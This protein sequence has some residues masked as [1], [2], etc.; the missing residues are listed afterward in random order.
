VSLADVLSQQEKWDDAASAAREALRLN[1]NNDMARSN[2]GVVLGGKK[3]MDGMIAEEREALRVNPNND[4]AHAA[5][6]AALEKKGDQGGALQ[7]YRAAYTLD[8]KNANY[9]KEYESAIQR[10][11][12]TE[13]PAKPT[14]SALLPRSNGD[15]L[16]NAKTLCIVQENGSPV[17]K[18]E[19]EKKLLKWGHLTLV[20]SVNESDL[21]LVIA[22][23]G[24]LNIVTGE[25]NQAAVSLKDR[26]SGAVLWSTTKGGGWSYRGFSNAWVGRAIADELTKFITSSTKG[27][28]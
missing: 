10:Q 14:V 7:E 28:K 16:A 11:A 18:A 22:Q 4:M 8:P 23:A 25:G 15:V 17:I 21:V 27:G 9:K 1:P 5:L 24:Q 3:D 13:I 26:Q 2:L 20:S 6:G 12:A 19:V